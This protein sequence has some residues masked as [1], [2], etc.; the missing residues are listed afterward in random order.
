MKHGTKQNLL[1]ELKS[2]PYFDKELVLQLGKNK[3]NY[4]LKNT[5]LSVYISR[6]LKYKEIISLKRGM[7]VTTDFYNKNKNDVSYLFFIANVLR[8]PSYISSWTALQYYDLT[9]EAFNNI[10]SVTPK[11]TRSY[12]TKIGNFSY[13]TIKKDLFSNFSIEKG[14]FDFFI[15][16]PSKALFDLLYFK[17]QQFRGIKFEDIN[18]LIDELRIDIDEMDEKE[19]KNFF[20]MI[21]NYL[22][23]E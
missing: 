23:Y 7:Y 2:L 4:N 6:F 13:Q 18:L 22:H 21:K 14:N 5:T 12:K 19:K 17:T 10:T 8:S 20:L 9:T 15:A 1:E 16:S 11:I 3:Q